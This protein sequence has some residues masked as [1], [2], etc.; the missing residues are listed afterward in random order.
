MTSKADFTDEEWARLKRSPFVAGMGISLADPG[1]PIEAFKETSATL[2]SVIAAAERG[3]HG[4]LVREVASEDTDEARHHKNPL[5]GFKPT[6]GATAGVEIL[7]ELRAVNS[8]ISAKASADDAA[9]FRAWLMETAQAAANAAK[10]GGFM[11]FHAE[12]VSA[13]EQRM[14]DSLREAL[15]AV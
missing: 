8:I 11:G 3:E 2:K 9:A 10:E 5:G 1:G 13:G 12:R 6:K 4:D 7:D 15:T 14:L